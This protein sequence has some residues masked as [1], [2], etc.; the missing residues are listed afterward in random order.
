MGSLHFWL[1]DSGCVYGLPM[2]KAPNSVS[3]G[4]HRGRMEASEDSWLCVGAAE[5]LVRGIE[6]LE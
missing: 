1:F 4:I 5:L 3:A 6:L 2:Y